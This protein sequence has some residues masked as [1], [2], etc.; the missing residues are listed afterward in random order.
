MK[1]L[2]PIVITIVV[3]IDFIKLNK[4]DKS[5]IF[6]YLFIVALAAAICVGDHLNLISTNPLEALIS[7]TNPITQWIQLKLQ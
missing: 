2:L 4:E 1:I 6:M 3:I 5:V 7:F